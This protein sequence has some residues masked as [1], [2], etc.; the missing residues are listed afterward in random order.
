M[1]LR[2]MPEITR[3]LKYQ[4]IT[5]TASSLLHQKANFRISDTL[6]SMPLIMNFL[7]SNERNAFVRAK[8]AL[9]LQTIVIKACDN[10][11]FLSQ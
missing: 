10:Y 2:T 9:P 1:I 7:I 4:S 6:I 5:S 8:F 11:L 3:A